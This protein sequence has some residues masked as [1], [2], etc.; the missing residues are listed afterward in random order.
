MNDHPPHLRMLFFVSITCFFSVL[1]AP[2]FA[3]DVLF[4][5][6]DQKPISAE[7]Y[8]EGSPTKDPSSEVKL[9]QRVKELERQLSALQ[10]GFDT[11][12]SL[13][14]SQVGEVANPLYPSP[15]DQM[16]SP[17]RATLEE[18]ALQV[19]ALALKTDHLAQ[20]INKEQSGESNGASFKETGSFET[21]TVE[22]HPSQG[23]DGL[24]AP[25]VSRTPL[26]EGALGD[27]SQIS[28]LPKTEQPESNKIVA[29]DPLSAPNDP[30]QE[31]ERAYGFLIQQNYAS[32]LAGFRAFIK[33]HPKDALMPHALYWLGETHNAQR[34]FEDAAEAFDLLVQ[35]YGN[36]PKAP[37]SLVKRGIALAAL[38]KKADACDV[39]G[40]LSVK[41]PSAAA[42]LKTKAEGERSRIGCSSTAR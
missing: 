36:S 11:L 7:Q 30:V 33:A 22:T 37:D 4:K 3:Q 16:A 20:K 12:Q 5:E 17:H 40:K 28:F 21:S 29:L 24:V 1:I 19:R 10:V 39:L 8:R 41:Y 26:S 38:G 14:K 27:K 15:E 13:L 42:A 31:Y 6:E 34:N 35:G 2:A 23:T 25:A 18:L 9:T 32:A